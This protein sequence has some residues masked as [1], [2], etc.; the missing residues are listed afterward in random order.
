[1]TPPE[2]KLWWQLR[3]RQLFGLKFKRQVPV[4]PYIVDFMCEEFGLVVEVDGD[5]HAHQI[6]YDTRRDAYLNA[7][8]FYVVRF[9]N[10]D[11]IHNLDGVLYEI[12]RHCGK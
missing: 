12:A 4:G 6:A 5:T 7:A 1:M 9:A 8:G 11:V 2:A 10:S 3:S